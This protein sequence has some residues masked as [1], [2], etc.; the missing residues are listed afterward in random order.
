MSVTKNRKHWAS[1]RA[2]LRDITSFRR[3]GVTRKPFKRV[4]QLNTCAALGRQRQALASGQ[5]EVGAAGLYC[6]P[7]WAATRTLSRGDPGCRLPLLPDLC[8]LLALVHLSL[9]WL[10]P[11]SWGRKAGNPGSS[12][13]TLRPVHPG[14]CGHVSASLS[15]GSVVNG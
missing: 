12:G 13:L 4:Y 2:S 10:S 1:V 9:P 8:F 14:T 3:P 7:P 11:S 5:W 15:S 6:G